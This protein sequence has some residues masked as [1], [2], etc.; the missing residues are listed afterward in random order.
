MFPANKILNVNKEEAN[1]PASNK[2]MKTVI[3][4]PSSNSIVWFAGID[5]GGF[6]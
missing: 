1:N 2:P 3:L 6:V 4:G 5:V